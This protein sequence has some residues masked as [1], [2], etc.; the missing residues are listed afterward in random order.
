MA[1]TTVCTRHFLINFNTCDTLKEHAT[2]G[3]QNSM[4]TFID[5]THLLSYQLME[6]SPSGFHVAN[7]LT[8]IVTEAQ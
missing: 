8:Y 7:T 1:I 2:T 3:H 4:E 5:E 6:K